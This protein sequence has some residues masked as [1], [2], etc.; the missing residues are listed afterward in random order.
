MNMTILSTIAL[1]A[2]MALFAT[3]PALAAA[4]TET[5]SV[6][7]RHADL[8]LTTPA[9]QEVLERRI[10]T[11]ARRLCRVGEVTT[12]TRIASP[13]SAECY[14]KAKRSVH[15]AVTAAITSNRRGG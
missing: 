14:R 9:G 3:T 1:C 10:D 11:A 4:L 6:S 8:D 13:E 15:D 2:P 7:V 5:A 12:G